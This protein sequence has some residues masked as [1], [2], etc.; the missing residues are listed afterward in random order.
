MAEWGKGAHTYPDSGIASKWIGQKK[1]IPIGVS[2]TASSA[3]DD[4]SSHDVNLDAGAGKTCG[5]TLDGVPLA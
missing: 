5:K 1:C 3:W 2:A 4:Y